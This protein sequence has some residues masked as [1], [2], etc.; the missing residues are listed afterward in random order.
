MARVS[1]T[2]VFRQLGIL[3]WYDH[4]QLA[5]HLGDREKYLAH[6]GMGGPVANWLPEQIVPSRIV[7]SIPSPD[8]GIA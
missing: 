4:V 6:R 7:G 1:I 3:T 5:D 8:D 2:P